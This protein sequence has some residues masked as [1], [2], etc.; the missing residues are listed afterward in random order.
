MT[1]K[2]KKLKVESNREKRQ[3]QRLEEEYRLAGIKIPKGVIPADKS[4]QV[5]NNSYSPP[6]AFYIDKEFVCVDCGRTEV[7]TARQQKW[8]YEVAKGSLYAT[9]VRCRACRKRFS[10]QKGKGDPNP[11]KHLGVLMKRV[12]EIVGPSLI[13]A[14]CTF[15]GK[16]QDARRASLNYSRAGI[17]LRLA[18]DHLDARLIAETMDAAAEYRIV[19]SVELNVV[20][21]SGALLER[22]ERFTSTVQELLR[23]MNTM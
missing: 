6:P 14:G 20:R 22:I 4:R 2:R 10:E 23:S 11:I 21:S 7:W 13:E 12:R 17:L 8:Y 15:E 1:A 19:A 16:N 5:P 18:F 9:A 3:L